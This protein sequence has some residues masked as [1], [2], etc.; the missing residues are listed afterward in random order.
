M[1]TSPVQYNDLHDHSQGGLVIPNRLPMVP[2]Q[3]MVVA[4]DSS[5]ML[6]PGFGDIFVNDTTLERITTPPHLREFVRRQ[7]ERE[8]AKRIGTF[9]IFTRTDD[10][11]L[12]SLNK[13]TSSSIGA[14]AASRLDEYVDDAKQIGEG[15]FG[16]VFHVKHKVDQADYALKIIRLS[17]NPKQQKKV[18]GEVTTLAQLNHS[19]IVRY[20]NS[21]M[22]KA[23]DGW[24]EKKVWSK[25]KSSDSSSMEYKTD[26]LPTTSTNTRVVSADHEASSHTAD[27]VVSS[28]DG[29]DPPSGSS[30][31]K[32]LKVATLQPTLPLDPPTCLFIQTELCKRGTLHTWLHETCEEESRTKS[33]VLSFFKQILEALVCIHKKGFVHRDLKPSNV[34]FSRTEDG[35][36]IGD[37]GL[38][39]TVAMPNGAPTGVDTINHGSADS[40]SK[41]S[42][43]AGTFLYMSPEQVKGEKCDE[44]SDM[45]A[46]GIILF[47][48]HYYITMEA[49]NQVLSALRK[50]K[51]PSKF[52]DNFLNV[53]RIV[54]LLLETNPAE[55]PTANEL[56]KNSSLRN[57]SKKVNKKQR[58]LVP[59]LF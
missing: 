51:F 11:I 59:V 21:W 15:G 49:R 52:E 29:A 6:V 56:T 42:M 43:Q 41:G 16:V 4:E 23:P 44:K 38:V 26:T 2:I 5:T 18:L 34:F 54:K 14:K 48:L 24:R 19:H 22:E 30:Q 45:F 32:I 31:F 7:Q 10:S 3:S 25:L 37:F 8:S 47:E 46:L 12:P 35:L 39:R 1:F 50:L 40:H 20:F 55:R 9:R 17:D 33:Q 58:A 36:K 57:L 13:Q 53:T 27:S 28:R